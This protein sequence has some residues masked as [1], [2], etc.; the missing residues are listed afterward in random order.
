[1]PYAFSFSPDSQKKIISFFDAVESGNVALANYHFAFFASLGYR[2][3]ISFQ[4]DWNDDFGNVWIVRGPKNMYWDGEIKTF[5][6]ETKYVLRKENTSWIFSL[7]CE[8]AAGSIRVQFYPVF[9]FDFVFSRFECRNLDRLSWVFPFFHGDSLWKRQ[10]LLD[11]SSIFKLQSFFSLVESLQ[12]DR[13]STF[14]FFDLGISQSYIVDTLSGSVP[15]FVLK[16]PNKSYLFLKHQSFW[17]F[18]T[19]S[20]FLEPEIFACWDPQKN[21]FFFRNNCE[22][23]SFPFTFISVDSV[24]TASRFFYFH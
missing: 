20:S 19:L 11:F 3:T 4:K 10:Y 13:A 12:F 1:M 23:L 2:M 7:F 5:E 22:D 14:L 8:H 17:Y 18:Y 16:H 15:V 21:I 9:L 24:S 6:E